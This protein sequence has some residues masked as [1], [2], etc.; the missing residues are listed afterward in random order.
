MTPADGVV[1]PDCRFPNE[2]AAIHAKG[3][4]VW[5]TMHGH[6]LEGAAGRHESESYIDALEVDAIVPD[7][8]LEALPM[9]VTGMLKGSR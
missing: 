8:P 5:K 4:R 7:S 2:V 9:I 1:I 6:G 3:G